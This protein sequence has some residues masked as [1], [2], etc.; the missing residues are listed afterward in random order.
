[1]CYIYDEQIITFRL[2]VLQAP[3]HQLHQ[4]PVWETAENHNLVCVCELFKLD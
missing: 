2:N 1:M 3:I 4:H